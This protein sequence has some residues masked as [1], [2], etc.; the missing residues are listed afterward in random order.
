MRRVSLL[1]SRLL[2]Y[3]RPNDSAFKNHI[4][5]VLYRFR[6]RPRHNF[7]IHL[8]SLRRV[9]P[10]YIFV[11]SEH[12]PR[13]YSVSTAFNIIKISGVYVADVAIGRRPNFAGRRS[14]SLRVLSTRIMRT[15]RSS[16][17]VARCRSMVPS[18][19][20]FSL[21]ARARMWSTGASLN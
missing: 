20:S 13:I 4:T 14:Y 10:T 15:D 21:Q 16:L 3:L 2:I 18:T 17:H 8:V 7:C 1:N 12:S 6:S 9:Q 5:T 19:N 11:H